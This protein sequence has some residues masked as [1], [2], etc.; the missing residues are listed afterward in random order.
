M[1][2]TA[3]NPTA[4]AAQNATAAERGEVTA[5]VKLTARATAVYAVS[6]R[7]VT[8]MVGER[9]RDRR[10]GELLRRTHG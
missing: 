4:A 6:W 10:P 2:L 1:A 9:M 7:R 8:S 5:A 3:A